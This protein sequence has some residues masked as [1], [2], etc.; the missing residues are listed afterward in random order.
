MTHTD[1]ASARA[2]DE[3]TELIP[4]FP[5]ARTCPYAPPD[6][7]LRLAGQAPLSRVRL[8]D[9]REVWLV[10]GY[11]QARAL[12]ADPR[13]SADRTNPDFPIVAPRLKAA[14]ARKVPLIGVDAPEH[15]AHRRLLNPT[16]ALKRV[17]ATRPRVEAVVGELLDRLVEHGPPADLVRGLAVPLPSILTAELLG[18]PLDDIEFFQDA[19]E[20]TMNSTDADGL[21]RAAVE[22]QQYM[23]RQAVEQEREPGPGLIGTLA[24]H[25]REGTISRA[26]MVQILYVLLIAG[27]ETTSGSIAL[28]IVTL[29]EHPEQWAQLRADPTLAPT[30]VEELLRFVAVTDTAGLRV[31]TD[32][33]E[34][35]GIRLSKGDGLLLSA[36]LVNR[37]PTVHENPHSFDIHRASRRHLAFGHGVHQCVGQHLAR[38]ELEVVFE[39]LPR[40]FPD[41]RLA[42]PVDRLP[43]RGVDL[44]PV[45]SLLELPVIW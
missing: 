4:S 33:I 25:V 31:L 28:G 26:E 23:V 9:G 10:T 37:D 8:Y 18:V 45:Q 3:N 1:S 42:V 15:D 35:D 22:L 19:T 5:Q 24:G 13:V 30:V 21:Q 36:S 6:T 32:D 17:Q 12:L 41:L 38:L 27:H 2:D 40:R 39:A 14:H 16:F 44:G 29:L 34:L 7:L 11:A 20:R 43:F